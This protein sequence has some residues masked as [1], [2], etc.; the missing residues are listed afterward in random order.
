MGV[1]DDVCR[2]RV[3]VHCMEQGGDVMCGAEP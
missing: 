3:A 1:C 2:V